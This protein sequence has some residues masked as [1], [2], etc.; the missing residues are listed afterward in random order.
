MDAKSL[1][2][3]LRLG[4]RALVTL[5]LHRVF[6][7]EGGLARFERNFFSE[8]LLPT[9]LEDRARL[10][11]CSRCIACGLCDAAF[12]EAGAPERPSL[13]PSVF[14]RSA[15]EL[16][17]VAPDVGALLARGE[18]LQAAERLCP[19]KVPLAQLGQWL[20]ERSRRGNGSPDEV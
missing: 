8:G 3:D 5:P 18:L 16:P 4:V 1:V 12:A 7:Q 13:L 15:V 6:T 20:E 9:T 10:R 17:F 19:R 2:S 14:A 11:E